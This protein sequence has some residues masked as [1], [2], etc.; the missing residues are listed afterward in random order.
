MIWLVLVP[1]KMVPMSWRV[2]Y[3]VVVEDVIYSDD[4]FF[5]LCV[6]QLEYPR[7]DLPPNVESTRAL[8]GKN[9][10]K[11]EP[12][13]FDSFVRQDDERALVVVTSGT[14]ASADVKQSVMPT[15]EA[16]RSLPMRVVVCAVNLH[17]PKDFS[18]L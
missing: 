13:W 14:A 16:C 5:Q 7:S 15:V 11:S 1:S 6:P 4:R 3:E 18:M 12:D 2:D 10:S 17:P 9:D 8:L